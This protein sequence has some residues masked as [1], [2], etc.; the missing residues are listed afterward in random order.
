MAY[1]PEAEPVHRSAVTKERAKLSWTAFEQLHRDAVHLAY[2]VWPSSEEDAWQGLSVF[3]IDGSKFHRPASLALRAAFDPDSGL[4]HCGKG[5]Y[6]DAWF[7]PPTI[8]FAAYPS[9]RTVK[10][11]PQAN[12]R[13]EVKAL[14]PHIPS[15]GVLRFDR[16]YPSD[17]LI[18]SLN[19][20]DPGY[21]LIRC[22]ASAHLC[23]RRSLRS[24]R[25]DPSHDHPPA[26]A[27]RG[28]HP[29]RHSPEPKMAFVRN[30][31]PPDHGR[32]R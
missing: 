23:R 4:D 28:D 24:I 27:C 25:P 26:T 1:G 32:Y 3:A 8:S 29:A 31:S 30:S 19:R 7:P 18:D 6:P 14:L 11:M 9:A 21:W 12:E 16:G 5:H 13:E 2:E 20:H 17:E 10:P 15:G 22:P